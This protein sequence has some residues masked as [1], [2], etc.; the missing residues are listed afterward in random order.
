MEDEML[1]LSDNYEF[2]SDF[3]YPPEN[4]DIEDEERVLLF[5]EANE[6][7]VPNALPTEVNQLH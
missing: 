1:Y 3:E 6:L 5:Q 2:G 7:P 4:S